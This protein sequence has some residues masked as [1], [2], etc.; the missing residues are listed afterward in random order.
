MKKSSKLLR[1]LLNEPVDFD[2][3][4][5]FK[6]SG[7]SLVIRIFGCVILTENSNRRFSFFRKFSVLQN[8]VQR[9]IHSN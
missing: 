5:G 8:L 7:P 2:F 3:V 6:I 9:N 4:F 1:E